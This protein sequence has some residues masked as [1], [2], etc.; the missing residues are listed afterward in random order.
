[1]NLLY[2]FGSDKTIIETELHNRRLLISSDRLT[3][4]FTLVDWLKKKDL[5][6]PIDNAI[7]SN[8]NFKPLVYQNADQGISGAF[9]IAVR[10]LDS[11]QPIEKTGATRHREI[12]ERGNVMDCITHED[13]AET[14]VTIGGRYYSSSTASRIVSQAVPRDPYTNLPLTGSELDG[15]RST[16]HTSAMEAM[17]PEEPFR[18]ARQSSEPYKSVT[19]RLFAEVTSP[20]ARSNS[21]PVSETPIRQRQMYCDYCESY[22][23]VPDSRPEARQIDHYP[24]VPVE[25]RFLSPEPTRTLDDLISYGPPR[26]KRN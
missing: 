6:Q 18:L 5:F 16:I 12:S 24:V 15:A 1:M 17:H 8:A 21:A 23:T 4:I 25:H 13:I 10:G 3:D 7:V 11:V 2:I 9:M 22:R 26:V 14:P 20:L 19:K